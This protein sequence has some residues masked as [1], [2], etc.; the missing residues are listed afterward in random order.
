MVV[1][2]ATAVALTV[3]GSGSSGNAALLSAGDTH[4]LIDAGLSRRRLR[5]RI[6]EA[7]LEFE[8][9]SAIVLTHEH[10]DHA[11]HA[12]KVSSEFGCPIY[13]SHGT[14]E[15]LEQGKVEER[16]ICFQPGVAFEVGDIKIHPFLVSHDA[17][18]P[19]GFRFESEGVKI[20][21]AVDLGKLTTLVKYHLQNCDCILIEANYDVERLRQ[22]PYPWE[23]KQR[24][25]Q[26]NGHLSNDDIQLFIENDFDG[27]ARYLVLAHLSETNNLP[28]LVRK[29]IDEA[30][31][32]C[33]KRLQLPV[34]EKIQVHVCPRTAHLPTLRF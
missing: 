25:N 1:E 16:R 20:A 21:Y 7:G 6:A 32:K 9:L 27:A 23:I 8:G 26:D 10:A 3:L 17:K 12:G 4:L 18:E 33:R 29:A 13:L 19:V 30:L 15:K 11:A 22:G 2:A 28:E 5:Q 31:E 24:I 34:T 14:S